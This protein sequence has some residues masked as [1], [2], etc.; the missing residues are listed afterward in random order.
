MAFLAQSPRDIGRRRRVV[1]DK[2]KLHRRFHPEPAYTWD[3]P[4]S[5]SRRAMQRLTEGLQIRRSRAAI[6]PA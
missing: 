1:L 2:K 3:T 4:W 5:L 6:A